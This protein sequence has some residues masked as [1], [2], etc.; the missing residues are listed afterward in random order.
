MKNAIENVYASIW[1]LCYVLNLDGI[2][3]ENDPVSSVQIYISF[4][5]FLSLRTCSKAQTFNI[6]YH[7][8]LECLMAL[9]LYKLQA[10]MFG[11]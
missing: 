1:C 6:E 7:M 8:C 5:C 4:V 3:D 2:K 10:G 9:A 11:I